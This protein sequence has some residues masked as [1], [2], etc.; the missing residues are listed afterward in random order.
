MTR[1]RTALSLFVSVTVLALATVVAR[2]QDYPARPVTLIVPFAPGASVDTIGRMVGQKLS[3]RLGKPVIVENRPGA[4]SA[5]G[6]IAVARAAPD[7]YTLL[8]APSG[9]YAI[10]PTLY[11]QL[12]YDPVKELAP[13]ALVNLDPLLLVVNPSLPVHSVSDLIKLA[14]EK[15]G[16][17]SFASP[18]A[19]TSLH[20]LGELLK[21]TAG[22]NMVHVPYRGGAPAL[23]DVI[24]G[25]VQLMFSDP[26]SAVPQAKA[27]KVRALGVSSST[28]LPAA[29]EIPTV[30]EAGL[31]GFAMVSWQMIATPAGT[32]KEIVDR[33][34]AEIKAVMALPEIQKQVGDR[35]QVPVASPAPA[36]LAK[37]IDTE[38]GRWGKIV[39]QAGLAGS[40]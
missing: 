4:G 28:R 18:G 25:Q 7:G 12:P 21:T 27:G 11:K 15:P 29:P 39:Q 32:P 31:P 30:A 34:N 36:E 35:G 1:L 33:L 22:I 8:L 20:L 24:A 9:T 5:T 10:N 17:L 23:Q 6:T 2:A 37:F 40:L 13:V 26:A 14:K 38:T 16:Q 19:G 3:E